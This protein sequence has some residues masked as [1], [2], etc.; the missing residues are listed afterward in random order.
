M[1]AQMCFGGDCGASID[2]KPFGAERADLALFNETAGT[3]IVEVPNDTVAAELFSGVAH[4][5]LGKTTEEKTIRVCE[6]E[7]EL[8]AAD[9]N[10]L[11]NSWQ[12][13][14]K[15]VLSS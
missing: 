14:L 9:L 1:L 6:G 15:E 13:P 7:K 5:V 2:V 11:K 4:I 12:A 3:F 8:F 10:Q